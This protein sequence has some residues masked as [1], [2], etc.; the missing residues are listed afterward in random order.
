MSNV[1]F[2]PHKPPF[3]NPNIPLAL[4]LAVH[5]EYLLKESAKGITNLT[6]FDCIYWCIFN[7]DVTDEDVNNFFRTYKEFMEKK[8]QTSITELK[9]LLVGF[10]RITDSEL[11]SFYTP[12][13]GD[14]NK[15][16]ET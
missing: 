14:L 6:E 11:V 15:W 2:T 10:G 13:I 12:Y 7:D 1:L 4:K 16:L 5:L 3:V 9:V 8:I